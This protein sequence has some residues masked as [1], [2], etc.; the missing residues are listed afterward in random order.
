MTTM[1][2]RRGHDG[3]GQGLV[4]H[5]T[6]RSL[7]LGPIVLIAAFVSAAVTAYNHG[8]VSRVSVLAIGGAVAV[9]GLL[10]LRE[11]AAATG[12]RCPVCRSTRSL[13]HH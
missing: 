8:D 12:T 13:R 9:A 7:G 6:G 10:L 5:R 4:S 1:A 3:S 11:I 2:A